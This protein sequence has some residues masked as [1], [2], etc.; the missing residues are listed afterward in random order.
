M[1][2]HATVFWVAIA[3]LFLSALTVVGSEVRGR[4]QTLAEL[5]SAIQREQ[6]KIHVLKAERAYLASPERIAARAATE[7]GLIEFKATHIREIA[8]LPRWAPMPELE[9]PPQTTMPLLLSALDIEASDYGGLAAA[10]FLPPPRLEVASVS[11]HSVWPPTGLGIQ[12]E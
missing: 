9:L 3:G 1:I 10:A 11:S 4:D 6:E 8:S 7:L 12:T 2:R 5:Q